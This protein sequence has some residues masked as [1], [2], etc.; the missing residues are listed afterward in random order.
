V[1]TFRMDSRLDAS[2]SPTPLPDRR[3]SLNL[4]LLAK[5]TTAQREHSPSRFKSFKIGCGGLQP[6]ELFSLAFQNSLGETPTTV[7]SCSFRVIVCP[8]TFASAPEAPFPQSIADDDD[9]MRVWR[10]V[11]FGKKRPP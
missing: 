4:E 10:P 6:S 3:T 5:K 11:L 2:R 8:R 9:R 1:K 7:K